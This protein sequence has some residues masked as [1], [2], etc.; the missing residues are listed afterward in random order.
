MWISFSPDLWYWVTPPVMRPRSRKWD[1]LKIG[2]VRRHQV[3]Q[4]GWCLYGVRLNLIGCIY[5]WRSLLDLER[6]WQFLVGQAGDS[7]PHCLE[8]SSM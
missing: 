3:P 7:F 6:P 2:A 4:A 1:C 8:I 5:R